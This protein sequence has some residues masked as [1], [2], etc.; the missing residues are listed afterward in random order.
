[1]QLK[2]DNLKQELESRKAHRE[3][4]RYCKAELLQNN[5]SHSVLEANK[6]LFQRIRDLSGIQ[7]DGITL[8]EQILFSSMLAIILHF[9]AKL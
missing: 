3:V 5:Y 9:V 7:T 1:M 8:I 4:F 2:A 6:G